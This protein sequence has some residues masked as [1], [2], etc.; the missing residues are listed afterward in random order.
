MKSVSPTVSMRGVAWVN[1][2]KPIDNSMSH[3][4]NG[5]TAQIGPWPPLLRFHN[6]NVLRC[7]EYSLFPVLLLPGGCYSNLEC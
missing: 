1:P 3:P 5:A 2:L 4:S 7:V 6:N